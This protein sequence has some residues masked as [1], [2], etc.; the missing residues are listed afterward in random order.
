MKRDQWIRD[1]KEGLLQSILL[2]KT[3][4]NIVC[5]WNAERAVFDIGVS[6]GETMYSCVVTP[7]E[8][9]TGFEAA[10]HIGYDIRQA[11]DKKQGQVGTVKAVEL[12]DGSIMHI[13]DDT[14][15]S[16]A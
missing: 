8:L 16:V 1:F 7:S 2:P 3:P 14:P 12:K 4:T 15:D 5:E 11:L 9:M 13:V 6:F 10:L